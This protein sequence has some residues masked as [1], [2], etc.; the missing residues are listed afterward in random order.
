MA[1]GDIYETDTAGLYYVDV[2]LWGTPEYGAVYV[3]DG[4]RPAL[5]EAGTGDGYEVVLDALEALGVDPGELA[6][7]VPTHVH[8]DH[9]GGA[10]YLAE[11]CPNADVYVHERGAAH[12]I[13][14]GRLW[15][16]TKRAVGDLIEHYPEPRPIPE[17]RVVAV[18][19]G[20][21]IDLGE[22][23]LDV[24]DAPGHAPHQ[25]VFAHPATDGVFV[26]DAAGIYTLDG[27]VEPTTPPPTFD[28]EQ[29]LADVQTLRE[30]DPAWLYYSHF[31]ATE[32]DGLLEAYVE[33]LR[34]W[35]DG[36]EAARD[37][38]GDDEA[39]VESFLDDL[40][41]REGWSKR[42]ARAQTRMNVRGVLG[43]LERR[44]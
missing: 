12:L 22:H 14:P 16:G 43:Y 9:A 7:I 37:R 4:N 17:E 41:V 33:T 20:D 31:G 27:D 36:I 8:L 40:A 39:V 1:R 15:A 35:V 21:T 3:L 30:L 34:S 24:Y 10:G 38:L 25:A 6:A 11:A 13:D 2:G 19:G 44:E 28:F 42:E 32:A 5:V 26:A 23:A 29:C 18:A